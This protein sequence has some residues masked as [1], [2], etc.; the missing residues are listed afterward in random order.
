MTPAGE[1]TTERHDDVTAPL[2]APDLRRTLLAFAP[3][4]AVS[5][6][7]VAVLVAGLDDAARVSK[8][9]LMPALALFVVSDS[10]LA[11]GRFLPGYEFP[12]HDLVVMST[13]LAAQGLIA[14]GVVAMLRRRVSSG[15]LASTA[16]ASSAR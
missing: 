9:L 7:H 8:L 10:V 5:M 2:P 13:Y 4:V 15:A 3:Y 1:T 16:S 11:L 14:L 12:P 6:L